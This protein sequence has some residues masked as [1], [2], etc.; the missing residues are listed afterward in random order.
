MPAFSLLSDDDAAKVLTYIRNN[1]GNK[2]PAV[3]ASD[4]RAVRKT[5]DI[6]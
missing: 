6:K 3:S 5:L 4:V 1:F 2:A